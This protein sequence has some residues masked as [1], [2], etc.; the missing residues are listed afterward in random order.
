[1]EA[2]YLSWD[3]VGTT[4]AWAR[5]GRGAIAAGS[6][7][8]AETDPVDRVRALIGS[9]KTVECEPTDVVVIAYKPHGFGAKTPPPVWP[10]LLAMQYADHVINMISPAK[11][12]RVCLAP[13]LEYSTVLAADTA[14][15]SARAQAQG[16]PPAKGV[17]AAAR[18]K[19]ALVNA[20]EA[21]KHSNLTA[22]PVT[23]GAIVQAMLYAR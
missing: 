14:A 11:R 18:K 23:Y 3:Y 1:M 8:I 13:G 4:L 17:V 22:A 9:I 15:A 2:V 20:L 16:R 7:S 5:V 19:H 21:L 10:H 6:F 12:S